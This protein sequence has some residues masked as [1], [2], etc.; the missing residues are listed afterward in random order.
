MA[1]GTVRVISPDSFTAQV[2]ARRP[3][4]TVPLPPSANTEPFYRIHPV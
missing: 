3:T 2:E 1:E 4:S